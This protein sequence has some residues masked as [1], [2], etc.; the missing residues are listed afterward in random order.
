[1][2]DWRNGAASG[3]H[4]YNTLIF[5]CC[6]RLQSEGFPY[7]AG[8]SHRFQG[9][10]MHG[11]WSVPRQSHA[12]SGPGAIP[13]TQSVPPVSRIVDP[14]V[15]DYSSYCTTDGAGRRI[16]GRKSVTF[17]S[18][19]T[20]RT[21]KPDPA[22]GHSRSRSRSADSADGPLETPCRTNLKNVQKQVG[23]GINCSSKA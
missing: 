20:V 23:F 15:E 1:M 16:T 3:Q 18:D 10:G 9:Q 12:L 19:S 5:L 7:V 11:T 13:V 17:H 14:S 4:C 2:H 21:R 6:G 22:E 8:A